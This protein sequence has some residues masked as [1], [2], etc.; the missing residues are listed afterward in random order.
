M[1]ETGIRQF[2]MA[3]AMVWGKPINPRNVE[4]LVED[5]LKTM[6]EFGAPGDDIQELLEGPFADP[7]VRKEFQQRAIQRTAR[8]LARVSPYYQK[9][10][11]SQ[12]RDPGKLT[13][14]DMPRVPVTVKQSLQKQQQ[15]FVTTDTQPYIA[16]RTTGTT[17]NPAEVWLSHYEIELWGGMATLSGLLRDEINPRDCM[18]IN[19]SSRATAAVHQNVRVC[20][21][22]GARVRVLGIIPP[23]ESVDSLLGGGDEAPTLLSTYPSYLAQLVKAARRR[24]LGPNDFKL[25]RIDCGGEV[26][27][28]ALIRAAQKTFGQIRINDNFGM[29]EVLPVSGRVCNQQHLHPDLNMGYV[30]VIDPQSGEPAAPGALGSLVVTPYYPYRE[31]M[32]VFR[33]DTR[34]MVRCL[35]DESLTCDL[36]AVPA[37]SRIQGKAE[38]ILHIDGK[39]VT[40]RDLV[41][42]F[43]TLPSEPWPARFQARAVGDHIEMVVPENLLKNLG[44]DEIEHH[45]AAAGIA[46]QVARKGV[47]ESELTYLR[48]LRADLLESTFAARRD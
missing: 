14:A 5:G 20:R 24:G 46:L 31:C 13:L 21:L 29:T 41:E 23:E 15:D 30:E 42:A 11:A 17:G 8:R 32:P 12:S 1:F 18:Q 3:M 47:P 36:A 26:L 40:L 35:P 10:F 48:P 2:R 22:A 34:D 9:L 7:N 43:E 33:Y 44:A 37:V 6:E 27:S 38:H 16:T 39:V 25:R 4:R 28:N 19:I 45:F